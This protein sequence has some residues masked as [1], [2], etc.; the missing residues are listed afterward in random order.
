MVYLPGSEPTRSPLQ[1]APLMEH[2]LALSHS[3]HAPSSSSSAT[4]SAS[5]VPYLQV[6]PA[7]QAKA[8]C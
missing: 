8:N 2:L 3:Q 6:V 1:V 4:G 5:F 7:G